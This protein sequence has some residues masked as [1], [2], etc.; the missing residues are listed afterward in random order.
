M[1]ECAGR[2]DFDFL[3]TVL[4]PIS[5]VTSQDEFLDFVKAGP[6]PYLG[7]SCFCFRSLLT[8]S[9][10]DASFRHFQEV[11]SLSAKLETMQKSKSEFK[12][13]EILNE[14][15]T[16]LWI[17]LT[18]RISQTTQAIGLLA[19]IF[20]TVICPGTVIRSKNGLG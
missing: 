8:Q 12:L 13:I 5:A 3:G 18:D 1:S 11:T 7:S 20:S 17:D 14:W 2:R 10:I 4:I 9:P 6:E 19:R 15:T 16:K